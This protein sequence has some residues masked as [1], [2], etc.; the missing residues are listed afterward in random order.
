MAP[1]SYRL[2]TTR[3]FEKDFKRLALDPKRRIDQQVRALE[4]LPYSG[5][6]LRG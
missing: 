4:T 5:K 1:M 6:R 3:R 2:E